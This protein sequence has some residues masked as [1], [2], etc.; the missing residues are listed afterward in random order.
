VLCA[1]LRRTVSELSTLQWLSG[2]C[3]GR[4][5]YVGEETMFRQMELGW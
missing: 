3:N 4:K 1:K 2:S 5:C